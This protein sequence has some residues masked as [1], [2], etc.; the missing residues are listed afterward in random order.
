[1]VYTSL[2]IMEAN[3]CV[4]IY[5]YNFNI[6]VTTAATHF[7]PDMRQSKTLLTID[8]R[9]S[10]LPRNSVFD[11]QSGDKCQS[12]TCFLT[13]FHLCSSI[14][15]MF[16]IAAFLVWFSRD[17]VQKYSAKSD[18]GYN[19]C[20]HLQP[21]VHTGKCIRRFAGIYACCRYFIDRKW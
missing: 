8:K 3:Y 6:L 16:S 15:L 14:E 7:T 20:A 10:K 4:T 2:L 18:S 17:E 12:K 9:E 5:V 11:Y 13:I 19:D 21:T 1:M